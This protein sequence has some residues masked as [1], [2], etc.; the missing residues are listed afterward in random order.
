MQRI[1]PASFDRSFPGHVVGVWLFGALTLFH[2]AISL[3]AVFNPYGGAVGADG[4]P[5]DSYGP[6]GAAAFLSLF[7]TMGLYLL[8]INVVGLVALLRYRSMIPF[9]ALLYFSIKIS[10]R[11]IDQYAPLPGRPA[12]GELLTIGNGLI[13]GYALVLALAFWPKRSQP[14][15]HA[16]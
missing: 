13:L 6:A 10:D 12:S 11:V 14:T 7:S 16:A 15:S 2:F 8:A 5:V 1:F 4:I 3:V 9:M